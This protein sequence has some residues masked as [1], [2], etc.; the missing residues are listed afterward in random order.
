MN[1]KDMKRIAAVLGAL[2]FVYFVMYPED[3][4]AILAPVA[5]VLELSQ[6]PSPWLY[7]VIAVGIVV[8]G[9]VRVLARKN[10]A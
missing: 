6:T 3:V 5:A 7:L 10:A 1:A 8:W 2:A 4:K 9:G